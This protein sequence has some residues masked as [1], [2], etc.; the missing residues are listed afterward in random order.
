MLSS[1]IFVSRECGICWNFNNVLGLVMR[2]VLVQLCLKPLE[3]LMLRSLEPL[4]PLLHLPPA[5]HVPHVPDA[6]SWNVYRVD[7]QRTAFPRYIRDHFRSQFQSA[8]QI[9][10]GG[11]NAKNFYL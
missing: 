3:L 4:E 2:R 10:G 5:P 7:E 9:R 11:A 1:A 8:A 6:A